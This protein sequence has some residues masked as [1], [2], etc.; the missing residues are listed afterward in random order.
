VKLVPWFGCILVVGLAA[1]VAGADPEPIRIT[2]AAPP[3]CP[4]EAEVVAELGQHARI[5]R[6]D[7]AD[8]R[9]FALAIVRDDAGFHG[10]LV[11]QHADDAPAKREVSAASCDEVVTAL[12]IVAALAVE[13]RPVP[14]PRAVQVRAPSSGQP[15]ARRNFETPWRVAL[16]AGVARYSG[17]TPSVRFGVPIFLAVSHGHQQVRAT[18][19]TTTSD[20]L[21]VASFRWVAGRIDGC[22]YV[23]SS[24]RFAAAPCAGIQLGALTGKGTTLVD[25]AAGDTRPWIAP[26]MVA[27]VAVRLG[28]AQIEVEGTLAAPI[29]RDHYYIGSM[30][31]VH[32]V[33]A[34]T[35]GV[36]TSV[37]IQIR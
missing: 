26:E 34:L 16:G 11:V 31:T 22:P 18:F 21:A 35:E 36:A 32:R 33:A 17:I 4:G 27:R 24:G 12:V 7:T 30:T 3:E 20:D 5:A 6:V 15:P 25:H 23:W 19:D 13:E 8:A 1:G 14:P 10:E 2:Y 28:R 29:E 37:A 9:T